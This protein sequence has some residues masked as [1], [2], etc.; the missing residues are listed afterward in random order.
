MVVALQPS[1]FLLSIELDLKVAPA[2]LTLTSQV[3]PQEGL[4]LAQVARC[5]LTCSEHPPAIVNTHCLP[6]PSVG[7]LD[8]VHAP[9]PWP[10]GWDSGQFITG[11]GGCAVNTRSVLALQAC[12]AKVRSA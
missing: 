2:H 8:I 3:G 12:Q 4:L 9:Q 7:R 5:G 6:M 1:D 10:C 11:V